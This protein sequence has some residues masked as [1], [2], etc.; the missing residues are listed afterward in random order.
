MMNAGYNGR[1]GVWSVDLV[2]LLIALTSVPTI[3]AL[4]EALRR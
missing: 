1:V 2:W 3:V 4:I